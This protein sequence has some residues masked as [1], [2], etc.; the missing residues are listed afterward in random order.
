MLINFWDV[1]GCWFILF[2]LFLP[3][4]T[5]LVMCGPF[6]HFIL[7]WIGWLVAP[8]LVIA[9]LATSFYWDTNPVL[10]IFAWLGALG[11]VKE[12]EKETKYVVKKVRR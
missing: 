10:C 1:N 3:R 11:G 9:I 8:R 5:M 12:T 2:L 6:S 4:L 7:Y